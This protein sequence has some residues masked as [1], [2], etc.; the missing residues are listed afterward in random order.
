MLIDGKKLKKLRE[1][2]LEEAEKTD[3]KVLIKDK[4]SPDGKYHYHFSQI[5]LADLLGI[6]L[7]TYGAIENANKESP[8]EKQV[9][10]FVELAKNLS[11]DLIDLI[12]DDH[13]LKDNFSHITLKSFEGKTDLEK[14]NDLNLY[15]Y[16]LEINYGRFCVF[17]TFPST[18]YYRDEIPNSLRRYQF[19]SNISHNNKKELTNREYYPINEVLCF[20]FNICHR[21]SRD[22]KIEILD[23][24]IKEFSRAPGNLGHS[25]KHLQIFEPNAVNYHH[26]S[27]TSTAIAKTK[28]VVIPSATSNYDLCIIKSETLTNQ[29]R[30]FLSIDSDKKLST[31]DSIEILQ[32]LKYCL[33]QDGKITTFVNNLGETNPKLIYIVIDRLS[34]DYQELKE[35]WE[36]NTPK[37]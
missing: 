6:K 37:N 35:K 22:E 2:K 8:L 5:H 26:N 33:E 17:N 7:G 31:P 24:I 9:V 29:V 36:S 27:P 15:F 28:T 4:K 13:E 25:N 12:K 10:K 18:I 20:A 23:K 3:K 16:N 19:L 14:E 11:V 30:R 21:R 32:S 34:C 1:E